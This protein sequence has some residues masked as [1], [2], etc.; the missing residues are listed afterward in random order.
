MFYSYDDKC[1][2]YEV[3]Y[4]N[5]KSIEI[6]I[7]AGGKVV[8]KVPKKT[9]D[10]IIEDVIEKRLKWIEEKLG[11]VEKAFK[12]RD[13]ETGTMVYYLGEKVPLKITRRK[14]D[15]G[16]ISFVQGEF[17]LIIPEDYTS[18]HIKQMLIALY[19][20]MLSPLIKERIHHYQ[21]HFKVRPKKITI[22]DQKTRWGSCSSS[23]TLSFNY[24][25]LMAPLS[26]IDYIVVHEMTHMEHMNHSKSYWK[27][28]HEIMPDYKSKE[29]FLK[30]KGMLLNFE[31]EAI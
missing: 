11:V 19:K 26:V 17:V 2:E 3:K 25:L 7:E 30:E 13:F 5:R 23:G 16:K 21:N 14:T 28:V 29:K 4:S 10:H 31:W 1:F 18:D 8:F 22:R 24:R 9:P 15:K 20:K 6:R 12:S 27:R